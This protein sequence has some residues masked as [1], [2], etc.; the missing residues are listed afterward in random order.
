MSKQNK[1][2]KTKQTSNHST[3]ARVVCLLIAGFMV[4]GL[5]STIIYS[6]L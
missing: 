3:V 5:F 2:G 1:Q 4:L 6:L